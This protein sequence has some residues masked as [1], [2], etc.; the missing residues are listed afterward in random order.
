MYKNG[1]AGI[2]K[3]S[4]SIVFNNEDKGRSPEGYRDYD[5]ITVTRQVGLSTAFQHGCAMSLHLA[6]VAL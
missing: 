1:Q 5:Q 4:V 3:A 2:T 6:S